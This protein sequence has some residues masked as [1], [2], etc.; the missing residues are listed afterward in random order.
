MSEISKCYR[1][2]FEMSQKLRIS[3]VRMSI[4]INGNEMTV[5][6]LMLKEYINVTERREEEEGRKGEEEWKEGGEG[7]KGE[8]GKEG[9][10]WEEGGR[11]GEKEEKTREESCERRKEREDEGDIEKQW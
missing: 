2:C 3:K 4:K 8:E 9:R 10:K 6:D 1:W 5:I 7:C 11:A